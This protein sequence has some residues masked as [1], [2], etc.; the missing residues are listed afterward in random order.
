M[1]R[2]VICLIAATLCLGSSQAFAAD[3][4]VKARPYVAPVLGWTGFYFGGNVGAAWS[5]DS[6]ST[7]QNSP[8][9]PFFAIDNAAIGAAASGHLNR[10]GVTG[11]IQAGYNWQSGNFLWGVEADFNYLGLKRS[12]A[13]TFPFPSTLPGGPVGPPTTFFSVATSVS[14]DWLF[15][16]RPRI[17]YVANNWLIYGT[18][19]LAVGRE[20]FTQVITLLPPFIETATATST[21]A[22]WTAGGGLEYR[23]N[24]RWSVKAEYLYVDLGHFGAAGTIAPAFAGFGTTSSIHVTENIARGGINYHF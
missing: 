7:V 4:P 10:T 24:P 11:G 5:R 6:V 17:G 2:R 15:T 22:G 1:S 12:T 3:L 23:I 20:K 14:N 18:G 9:P 13:G 16:A 19:G 21:R 8:V